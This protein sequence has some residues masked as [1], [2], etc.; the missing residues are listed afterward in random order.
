MLFLLVTTQLIRLLHLHWYAT[1]MTKPMDRIF[2]DDGPPVNAAQMENTAMADAAASTVTNPMA[3]LD[4][5]SATSNETNTSEP[6][7][8]LNIFNS[9]HHHI[10]EIRIIGERHSGTSF[11]TSFLKT[12][13]PSISIKDHFV[14]GKHWMQRTPEYIVDNVRAIELSTSTSTGSSDGGSSRTNSRTRIEKSI[15]NTN[16]ADVWFKIAHA[17][18]PRQVFNNTLVLMLVRDPYEWMEAMRRRPWHWP[19]HVILKGR[20]NTSNNNQAL[21]KSTKINNLRDNNSIL[22]SQQQKSTGA[23]TTTTITSFHKSFVIPHELDW[24]D[25]VTRPLILENYN[26]TKFDNSKLN[27]YNGNG[28]LQLLCQKGYPT[29]SISPCRPTRTYVPPSIQHIPKSFLRHLPLDAN[30]VVYELD[31]KEGEDGGIFVPYRHPLQLRAAKLLNF[32]NV[33]RQWDLGG[34]GIIPYE[35]LLDG[36]TE[37]EAAARGGLNLIMQKLSSVLKSD[38]ECDAY[39]QYVKGPYRLP[40]EYHAWI[41]DHASWDIERLVGYDL[42]PTAREQEIDRK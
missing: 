34:F 1:N 28:D 23:A 17:D 35:K 6:F 8:H 10:D 32:L 22:G 3:P 41:S 19:N 38:C 20:N 26:E 12:C 13:F 36:R 11:F 29:G 24:Q 14:A 21:I 5:T 33:E 39:E 37:T 9:D 18:N 30:N 31:E 42:I 27:G 16:V 2:K 15:G 7:F 4:C 40:D 25:F